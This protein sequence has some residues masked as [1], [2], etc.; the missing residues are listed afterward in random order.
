MTAVY[1]N[2][3]TQK[4][5][6]CLV[7]YFGDEKLTQIEQHEQTTGQFGIG[8]SKVVAAVSLCACV[9]STSDCHVLRFFLPCQKTP[10]L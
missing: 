5:G 2:E 7:V 3:E 6:V 9:K 1:D 10:H 4:K 8:K